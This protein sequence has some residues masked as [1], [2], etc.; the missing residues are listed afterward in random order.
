MRKQVITKYRSVE[1]IISLDPPNVALVGALWSLSCQMVFGVSETA[2][3]GCWTIQKPESRP[4]WVHAHQQLELRTTSFELPSTCPVTL[5]DSYV[6]KFEIQ[7]YLARCVADDA[8]IREPL[9]RT[10][11]CIC[12]HIRTCI[13]IYIEYTQTETLEKGASAGSA[14][15][16]RKR[17]R[18]KERRPEEGGNLSRLVRVEHCGVLWG[19]LKRGAETRSTAQLS[20]NES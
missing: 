10:H 8:A 12:T 14:T 15:Q 20:H 5:S 19:T 3:G 2:V 17:R 9:V 7:C 13:Y 11:A 6:P 1:A 16:Q 4:I 18:C